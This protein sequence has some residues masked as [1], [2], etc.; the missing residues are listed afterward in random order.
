[1][2]FCRVFYNNAMRTAL[3]IGRFQPF[4][5]GHLDIVK[6]ILKKNDRLIIGIGSSEK[7]F[8][9]KNPFTANER[10]RMLK[11]AIRNSRIKIILIP[12]IGNNEKWVQHVEKLVP[13]FNCVY[14]GSPLVKKLFKKAK[15][16]V[17]HIKKELNIS[18]TDIRKKMIKGAP[19]KH[20]VPPSAAKLLVKWNAQK[21]LQKIACKNCSS[22]SIR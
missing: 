19:W 13:P 3:F 22:K 9:P 20:L 6:K 2:K 18:A 12:D 16:K 8:L 4:H 1:M 14:T 10:K 5:N 17:I 11:T 7:F 21:R 15:Y